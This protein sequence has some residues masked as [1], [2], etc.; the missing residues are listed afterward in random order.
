MEHLSVHW[1]ENGRDRSARWAASSRCAPPADVVVAGDELRADHAL[2]LSRRD[3][4]VLWRGDYRGA[5]Q[6]L[7]A[8]KRRLDRRPAPAGRTPAETFRRHRRMTADRAHLLSRVL[9]ELGPGH[10]LDLPH[11]PDVAA[12]C[13]RAFG[14]AVDRALLPLTELLGVLGADRWRTGGVRVPVLD[15]TIHPHHGVF[16]P[17]RQDYLDLVARAPLGAAA[18]AFDIGTGT[19]VLAA[20]LARRGVGRVVATDLEPRAVECAR[21]N[22]DRL[23]LADRVRVERTDLFPVGRADL[24]VCNPPWLPGEPTSSLDAAVYDPGSRMLRGFLAGLP[25]HLADGG[26]GWLV[27]SDLAERLGLRPSDEVAGLVAGAGLA[28]VD[29]LDTRPRHRTDRPRD[30]LAEHRA[31]EVVSLWRVR[32]ARRTLSPSR[33]TVR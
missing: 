16:A 9:V 31:A 21:D 30:P 4:A 2:A 13:L 23:G 33:R 3:R 14:P 6:L 15:G 10:H 7:A 20:L 24:V 32:S 18:T 26:E 1:H 8:V 12:A 22:V 29:R 11:A 28:V 19:G 25:G 5:R 17:T 27:L